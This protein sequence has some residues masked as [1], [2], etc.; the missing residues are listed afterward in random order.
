VRYRTF[1]DRRAVDFAT[2]NCSF[3][4]SRRPLVRA[5]VKSQAILFY[6]CDEFE[7]LKN[8]FKNIGHIWNDAKHF[9]MLCRSVVVPHRLRFLGHSLSSTF[10][11]VGKC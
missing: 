4:M 7:I 2:R 11:E 6:V 3:C 8:N 5:C 1:P 10:F 9:A